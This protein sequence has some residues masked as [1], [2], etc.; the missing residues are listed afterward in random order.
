[1]GSNQNQTWTV[2][3]VQSLAKC[4]KLNLEF[5][6]R[7]REIPDHNMRN[8]VQFICT[9]SFRMKWDIFVQSMQQIE[10]RCRGMYEAEFAVIMIQDELTPFVHLYSLKVISTHQWKICKSTTKSDKPEKMSHRKLINL[11]EGESETPL[12]WS[13]SFPTC[14]LRSWPSSRTYSHPS[15]NDTLK[16]LK[17]FL[18]LRTLFLGTKIRW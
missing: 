15:A 2:G 18:N 3:P 12:N 14:L 13:I 5:G 16:H 7:F 9:S 4:P 8:S 11:L 17:W 10:L 6:S 1:M